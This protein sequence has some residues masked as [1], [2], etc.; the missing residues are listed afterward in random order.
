MAGLQLSVEACYASVQKSRK[1]TS[2]EY[3][4]LLDRTAS[5]MDNAAAKKNN[6]TRNP[7]FLE[8]KV[9]QRTSSTFAIIRNDP[10]ANDR[11]MSRWQPL[12]MFVLN[13]LDPAA[14]Q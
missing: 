8:E 4:Y 5:G 6:W 13:E 3:C 14:K 11:E 2:L 7:Y 10:T 1:V 12:L 9:N